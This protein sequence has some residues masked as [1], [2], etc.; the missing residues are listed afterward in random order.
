VADDGFAGSWPAFRRLVRADWKANPRD[1]KSRLVLVGFRLAQRAMGTP[2]RLRLRAVIPVALYRA[3]TEGTLA[4]ELRPKTRVGGGLSIYHGFGLVVN[5]H[6]VLGEGVTL[7]NGVT[8]G[9]RSNDGP[10]PT[11]GDGVE[12]GSG[13]MVLGGIVVGPG[14]MIGAGAVVIKDV[15]AGAT[16]VGNPARVLPPRG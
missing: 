10:S 1:V 8:I 13:S 15:P 14:A 12:F 4:L 11:I 2:D 7:R 9:R 16:A 6:A 5:D 3:W